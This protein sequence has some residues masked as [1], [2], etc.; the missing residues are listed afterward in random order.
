MNVNNLAGDIMLVAVEV[1]QAFMNVGIIAHGFDDV[2]IHLPDERVRRSGRREQSLPAD[3]FETGQ[4]FSHGRQIRQGR[5]AASRR[6]GKR[7]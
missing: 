6:Y 3:R 2:G 4:R 1:D 7:K 5:H